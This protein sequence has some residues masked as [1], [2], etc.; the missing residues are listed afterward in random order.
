LYERMGFWIT[1]V[2]SP[3]VKLEWFPAV[4]PTPLDELTDEAELLAAICA[5]NH[6][7]VEGAL[8]RVLRAVSD[9]GAY[10]PD[11]CDAERIAATSPTTIEARGQVA[12][13]TGPRAGGYAYDPFCATIE[14]TAEGT[15]IAA[16]TLRWGDAAIGLGAG[17]SDGTRM[18]PPDRVRDWLYVF[19]LS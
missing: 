7:G 16:L 2:E 6:A 11:G 5:G 12:E 18:H 19:H 8:Y 15:S 17:A 13:I 1:A 14:L 3:R 10:T 9:D 4:V